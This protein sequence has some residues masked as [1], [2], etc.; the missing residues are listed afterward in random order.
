M[1]EVHTGVTSGVSKGGSGTAT[2]DVT[3][4]SDNVTSP[5]IT[6]GSGKKVMYI[7]NGNNSTIF[8]VECPPT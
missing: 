6:I 7:G 2:N 1:V 4:G 8:A 5:Y 3:G